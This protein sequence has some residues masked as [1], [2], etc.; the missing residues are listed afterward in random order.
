MRRFL[1]DQGLELAF[2]L[3]LAAVALI[4]GLFGPVSGKV[5]AVLA[6]L[7]FLM[8]DWRLL[9]LPIDL[10]LGEKVEC[11]RL[12]GVAACRR[13]AFLRDR[14]DPVCRFR[15]AGRSLDL[16]VPLGLSEER[17]QELLPPPGTEAELHYY[18][19]SRLLTDGEVLIGTFPRNTEIE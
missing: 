14:Y 10:L 13:Y 6:G 18:R 1:I 19:F 17:L 16:R 7:V 9:I 12:E 5:I 2:G 3:G 8:L 11:L 4:P 15:T